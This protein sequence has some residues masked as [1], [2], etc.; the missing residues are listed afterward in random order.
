MDFGNNDVETLNETQQPVDAVVADTEITEVTPQTE[1]TDEQEFYVEAEGDQE[2]PNMSQEQSYAAWKKEKEKRKKKQELIDKQNQ[3]LEQLRN[4]LQELRGAVIKKPTL[5]DC[6]YDEEVF[7]QRLSEYHSKKP[8]KP[9][10]KQESKNEA[11]LSEAAE[12]HLYHKEQD[13]TNHFKDYAEAKDQFL[14]SLSEASGL[15]EKQLTAILAET[16]QQ[17]NID[18][19]KVIYAGAKVPSLISQLAKTRSQIELCDVMRKAEAS[20]KQRK[21]QRIDSAPEPEIKTTG[22]PSSQKALEQYGNFV[23]VNSNG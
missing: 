19:A 4:E 3:E 17:G 8:V 6:D 13:I 12:Y 11:E 22:T 2:K 16:A 21:V 1:A 9:V 14:T 18:I 7:E 10:E 23:Q 5:A 15:N 20:I